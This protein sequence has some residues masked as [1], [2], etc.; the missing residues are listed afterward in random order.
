MQNEDNNQ[1]NDQLHDVDLNYQEDDRLTNISQGL[2]TLQNWGMK[3]GVILAIIIYII[4]QGKAFLAKLDSQEAA[5]EASSVATYE[6]ST[7]SEAP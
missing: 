4:M 3:I 7:E 5:A 1:Q 6:V 2:Y